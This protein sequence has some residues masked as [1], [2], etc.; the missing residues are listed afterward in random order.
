MNV[1]QPDNIPPQFLTNSQ[2]PHNLMLVSL[3]T[4]SEYLGSV[5]CLSLSAIRLQTGKRSLPVFCSSRYAARTSNDQSQTHPRYFSEMANCEN[6]EKKWHNIGQGLRPM[7]HVV[8]SLQVLCLYAQVAGQCRPKCQVKTSSIRL[9]VLTLEV[10]VVNAD[11]PFFGHDNNRNSVFS[12][13]SGTITYTSD[14]GWNLTIQVTYNDQIPSHVY[15]CSH[16]L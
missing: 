3:Q 2:R 13:A 15:I 16:F 11:V 5:S 8:H 7:W 6:T 4:D 10:H 1:H 12:I 9:L 14:F